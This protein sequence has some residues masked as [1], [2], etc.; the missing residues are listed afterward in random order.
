MAHDDLMLISGTAGNPIQSTAI[1][2]TAEEASAAGYKYVGKYRSG[3]V[4]IRLTG[5]FDRAQG[6]ETIDV[7]VK[8]ATDSAGSGAAEIARKSALASSHAGN[9]G[10]T[11]TGTTPGSFVAAG[12]LSTGPALLG[13]QTGS[14]GYIGL[15]W[16]CAGTSPSVRGFAADVVMSSNAFRASGT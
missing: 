14:G 1:T 9:T 15:F 13:F 4:E 2:T 12:S 10:T 16:D 3:V 5:H 8:E 7:I 11:T 6:D